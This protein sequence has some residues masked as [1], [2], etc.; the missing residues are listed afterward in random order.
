MVLV[1]CVVVFI[2]LLVEWLEKV[3]KTIDNELIHIF[4]NHFF[5]GTFLFFFFSFFF[6][7]FSCPFLLLSPLSHVLTPF[8]S[9]SNIWQL[10]NPE[11]TLVPLLTNYLSEA[12]QTL[13][14]AIFDCECWFDEVGKNTAE[15]LL[16]EGEHFKTTSKSKL[17][18]NNDN[19]SNN[20]SSGKNRDVPDLTIPFCSRMTIGLHT[21]VAMRQDEI[22]ITTKPTSSTTSTTRSLTWTETLMDKKFGTRDQCRAEMLDIKYSEIGLDGI[23]QEP[24]TISDSFHVVN[25]MNLPAAYQQP[26]QSQSHMASSVNSSLFT[27]KSH[28]AM[29]KNAADQ[30]DLKMDPAFP[31]DSLPDPTSHSLDVCFVGSNGNVHDILKKNVLKKHDI[32]HLNE[33]LKIETSQLSVAWMDIRSKSG[34]PLYVCLDGKICGPFIRIVLKPCEAIGKGD[35][36]SLPVSHFFPS[37]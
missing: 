34:K 33:S 1:L 12:K 14:I 16:A 9:N 29:S 18:S 11:K 10:P 7:L 32:E 26:S 23:E 28:D 19:E 8:H 13:P 4:Y 5:S 15:R 2:V 21:Q 36:L 27:R 3:P 20:T 30:I 31:M 22:Q 17:K 24:Q 35:P 6:F 25:A 37:D